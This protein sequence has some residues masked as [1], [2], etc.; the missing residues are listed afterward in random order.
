MY[1][2]LFSILIFASACTSLNAAEIDQLF[3]ID[4]APLADNQEVVMLT[5]EYQPG[6]SGSPHRHNAHT[7]VYVL[8]GSIAMQ[9]K[10]KEAQVLN[11]GDTFYENPDDIHTIGKN[12]SDSEKAKFLVFFI[13]TKGD[14]I[15]V[16]HSD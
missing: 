12:A 11:P 6:E 16:P 8:K 10:G 1:K 13:K 14:P 3:N 2:I 4:I 5:L 9:V 15:L 7:F